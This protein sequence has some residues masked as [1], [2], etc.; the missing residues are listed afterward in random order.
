M[1]QASAETVGTSVSPTRRVRLK[2]T[3]T[4]TNPVNQTEVHDS[5][6]NRHRHTRT[7]RLSLTCFILAVSNWHNND[8]KAVAAPHKEEQRK[9]VTNANRKCNNV[10]NANNARD[11]AKLRTMVQKVSGGQAA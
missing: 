8:P 9:V 11:M 5:L 6:S 3:T 2:T 1:E 7:A 4:F 10:N